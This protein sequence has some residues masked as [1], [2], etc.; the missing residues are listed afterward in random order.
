MRADDDRSSLRGLNVAHLASA[1]FEVLRFGGTERALDVSCRGFEI[2][3]PFAPR[4]HG[5]VVMEAL[6]ERSALVGERRQ[7]PRMG[8]SRHCC[9]IESKAYQESNYR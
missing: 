5:D 3:I 8:T 9:H 6:G 7:R 4:E 2:R 1:A